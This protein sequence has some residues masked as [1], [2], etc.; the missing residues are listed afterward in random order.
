MKLGRDPLGGS[1]T[2]L[3][4]A[5]HAVKK[6]PAAASEKITVEHGPVFR[7]I[8]DLAD[9]MHLRFVASGGN[10]GRVDSPFTGNHYARWLE[11]DYFDLCLDRKDIKVVMQDSIT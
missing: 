8:V 3:A 10:G 4:M 7:W 6:K 11:G 9:P 1:A 2:T 5:A